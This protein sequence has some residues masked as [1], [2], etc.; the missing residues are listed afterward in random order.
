VV[1]WCYANNLYVVLNCHWDGGWL[2]NNITSSVDPTINAKMGA[3]WTQIATTFKNYDSK[4]LFAGAN[5]PNVNSAA[6]MSTLLAYYQTF[7]NAVR[8]T[9]G[10]NSSRWLVV[11][12][13]N[14]DIDLTDSL[15][16]TLPTDPT[17]GRLAVEIHYYTPYQFT[18]MGSD[19]SWGNMFYFWGANYHSA[20]LPS[21]NS[22]GGEEAYVDAELQ[23]MSAKFISRNVPVILGEF[24]ALKRVGNPDLQGLNLNLHVAS[25]TYFD[26]YV[27]SSANAHGL[28]PFF[29][30]TPGGIFDWTSGASVDPDA[31]HA[32]TGGGALPPPSGE[33]PARL[34]NI[35]TRAQVGTGGAI[36]IPGFVVAGSGTETL[37]IRACG[38]GLTQYGVSGVLANPGLTVSDHTGTV[39][40]TNTG[41]GASPNPSLIASTAASVG[42]FAFAPGSADCALVV[43][44][45]A[46]AYTVQVSGVGNTTGIAL[47]EVY[48][49]SSTGTRLVNVSTR[50]D[51][52]TGGNILI[53]GFVVAG[54]G[55]DTLLVRA[56]G[57]SLAQ[58]NV[59]GVLAQ[60]TLA[61]LDA[62]QTSLASNTGWG[63]G[64]NP[65]V[66]A[67]TAA[68]VGAFALT[69]GSADS[70]QIVNLK[71]GAYTVLVSG[72]NGSTGV[73]LAEIYEVP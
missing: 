59:A 11:Q 34:I 20:T 73:A 4:L 16:N 10:N 39:I 50:T 25:V 30:N 56:D 43:S 28:K 2:E 61:V 51:V 58:F 42:A 40:A 65:N 37:L 71:P 19:A 22:T 33:N 24:C 54:S 23:K 60:P 44:L 35:S 36:L 52:G 64:T 68:N 57:P 3:Y 62:S 67:N 70:A 18:L 49:V 55:L 72:I 45:P 13:P 31:Q 66:I 69:T 38:P 14:T 12:G 15:M 9:G 5:E 48:E 46:G 21:R 29:W 7:V 26:K 41:W 17:P 47:A 32:L 6:Q 63:T 8:A 53:P 1:D 27:S